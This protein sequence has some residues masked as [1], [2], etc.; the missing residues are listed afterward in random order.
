MA[1]FDNRFEQAD[2][3]YVYRKNLQGRAVRV[4]L[5]EFEK[6]AVG[7]DGAVLKTA[8]L[9]I[10]VW[11]LSTAAL[12][13]AEAFL[14]YG[15]TNGVAPDL[16]LPIAAAYA[17][18]RGRRYWDR[19]D[20]EMAGRRKFGSDRSAEDAK[21]LRFALTGWSPIGFCAALIVAMCCVLFQDGDLA[22]HDWIWLAPLLFCVVAGLAWWSVRKAQ[23]IRTC[24][25]RKIGLRFAGER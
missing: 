2:G 22:A 21:L 15:D 18:W 5:G 11:A 25:A 9:T 8:F 17:F 10:L 3:Y 6:I 24:R 20:R 12:S 19:L 1:S 4:S 14:N 13:L 16:S 7:Y 23:A